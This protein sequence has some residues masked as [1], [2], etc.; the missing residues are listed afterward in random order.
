MNNEY[1]E[2]ANQVV[3][4]AKTLI[5]LA[6]RRARQLA[7]G[8][9]PMVRCKD[10][11]HLD[12]ALLEVAE[13]KL[14]ANFDGKGEDDFIKEINALKEAAKREAGEVNVKNKHDNE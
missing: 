6:S 5:L 14:A 4:D 11:N 9:R 13:G 10:E 12:V 7:C 2:R 8:A 1:L 3:P